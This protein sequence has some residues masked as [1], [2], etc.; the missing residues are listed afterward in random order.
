MLLFP[1]GKINLGLQVTGKRE[2]G[3]HNIASVF[4]PIPWQD[5]LEIIEAPELSLHVSGNAIPGDA[6]KNLCLLAWKLLKADFSRLP[7][8]SIYLHKT[9]PA[10]AG[11]GGG[12][13]NGA[14]MLKALNNL[15]KLDISAA[16]LI[17]Y[18]LQLGSDC[19][20]FIANTPAIATGRGEKLEPIDLKLT[21]NW[22]ILINPGIHVNTGWAFSQIT[23]APLQVDLKEIM[24]L[25][26]VEWEAAGLCNIFQ[27]PVFTH[28]PGITTA[29]QMLV[30]A[31]AA[32]AAMSGSGSTCFGLFTTEPGIDKKSMPQS[33]I[34]QQWQL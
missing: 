2:D 13:S 17:E 31:G 15:F 11:L 8:V 27:A 3:Y 21:G 33:W 34:F 18:A 1:N 28:Y 9:V 14:F 19:P 23:P 26:P 25:P 29:H 4:L 30:Q 22:L 24:Q 7:P 6:Q 16:Q 12:S 32:Y 20:F 5:A 10:G